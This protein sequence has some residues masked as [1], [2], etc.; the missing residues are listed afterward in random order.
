MRLQ[1]QPFNSFA[2]HFEVKDVGGGGAGARRETLSNICGMARTLNAVALVVDEDP[3]AVWD[4]VRCV[5][6]LVISGDADGC[7]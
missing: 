3:F 1:N 5:H 2:L 4:G 7:E 6:R